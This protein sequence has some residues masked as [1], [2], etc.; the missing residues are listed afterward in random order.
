MIAAGYANATEEESGKSGQG[1]K[2]RGLQTTAG[3]TTRTP[4]ADGRIR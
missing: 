2:P 4:G 3:G 1:E